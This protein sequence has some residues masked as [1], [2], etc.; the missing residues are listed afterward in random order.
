MTSALPDIPAPPGAVK[1]DDWMGLPDDPVRYFEGPEWAVTDTR[2][3]VLI[4]GAQFPDGRIDRAIC[5][6]NAE[7]L[8]SDQARGLARALL[9]AADKRDEL[10]H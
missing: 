8:S 9:A 4:D 3:K 6:R 10:D 5:V 7:G 1:V 2:A